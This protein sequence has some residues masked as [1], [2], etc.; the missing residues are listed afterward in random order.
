MRRRRLLAMTATTTAATGAPLPLTFHHNLLS[1]GFGATQP[2]ARARRTARNG[3][4]Y[5]IIAADKTRRRRR[6]GISQRHRRHTYECT[7]TAPTIIAR[8]QFP[9]TT[10]LRWILKRIC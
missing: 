5:D 9:C 1:P 4:D 2:A 8:N 3:T 6:R 10:L 7:T